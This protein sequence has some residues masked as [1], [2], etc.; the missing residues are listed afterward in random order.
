MRTLNR[1]LSY[2]SL[3]EIKS[4][5]CQLERLLDQKCAQPTPRR[6]VPISWVETDELL[7][8]ININILSHS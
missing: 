4:V 6:S 3:L 2:G 5:L 1:K 8:E 7:L